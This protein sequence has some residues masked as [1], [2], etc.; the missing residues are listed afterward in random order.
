MLPGAGE[1]DALTSRAKFAEA[2]FLGIYKHMLEALDPTPLL[3]AAKSDHDD[4][5]A[6]RT[7]LAATQKELDEYVEES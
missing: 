1:I 6:L 7:K 5:A 2:A 3:A 4:A